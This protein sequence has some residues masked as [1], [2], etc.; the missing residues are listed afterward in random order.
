LTSLDLWSLEVKNCQR[1]SAWDLRL[2]LLT[3][4][5]DDVEIDLA[6]ALDTDHE[7]ALPVRRDVVHRM[8]GRVRLVGT[9]EEDLGSSYLERAGPVAMGTATRAVP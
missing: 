9:V 6:F 4:I 2:Q 7:E 8:T 1:L 3:E 5:E